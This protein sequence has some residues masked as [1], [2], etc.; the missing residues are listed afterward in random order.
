MR[1]HV[2]DAEPAPAMIPATS[3]MRAGSRPHIGSRS[4][5]SAGAVIRDILLLFLVV[6]CI[7]FVMLGLG[8]PIALLVQLVSWIGGL[9]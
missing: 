3:V 6:L 8:L 5:G 7:P 2:I 1:S 9:L 4:I